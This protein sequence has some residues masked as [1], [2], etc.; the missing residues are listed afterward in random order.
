M[1]TWRYDG[2]AWTL[3][4]DGPTGAGNFVVMAHDA[5]RARTVSYGAR[6][7]ETW[8]FDGAQWGRA[9]LSAA[10]I[11]W[12]QAVPSMVFDTARGVLVL[13][14]NPVSAYEVETWESRGDGWTRRMGVGGRA[15]S[16]W[17]STT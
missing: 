12:Y 6:G 13:V 1:E 10:P 16:R 3:V 17:C 7:A 11:F 2:V 5:G 15:S 8:E 9:A 14:G 4:T